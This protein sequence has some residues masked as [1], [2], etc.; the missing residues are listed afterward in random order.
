VPARWQRP[1]E[2]GRGK[3]GGSRHVTARRLV[4]TVAAR[5]LVFTVTARKLVFTVAAQLHHIDKFVGIQQGA[6][7]QEEPVIADEVYGLFEFFGLG[8]ASES[9]LIGAGHYFLLT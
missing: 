1:D 6:A 3:P 4:F 2:S 9:E 7:K 8:V 5:R